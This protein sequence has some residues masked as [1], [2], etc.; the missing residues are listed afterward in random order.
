VLGAGFARLFAPETDGTDRSVIFRGSY[1]PFDY[2]APPE[3]SS[4]V[5]QN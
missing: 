1:P 3:S 2:F 5:L 4:L